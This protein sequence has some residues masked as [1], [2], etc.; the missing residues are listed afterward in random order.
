MLK[1]ELPSALLKCLENSLVGCGGTP[2]VI[3]LLCG[4]FTALTGGS[5]VTILA[6]GGLLLPMLLKEGY[7]KNFSLGLITVSGSVGLLFPPSLPLIIYGVTAGVSIKDIFIAGLFPGLILVLFISSWAVYQGSRGQLKLKNF[8]LRHALRV[9]WDTKWELFLPFL[10][11]F[12]VFGGYTTLVETSAIAVVY[13]FIVEVFIYKDIE[14][15][16]VPKI[17]LDCCNPNRGC[18]NYFRSCHGINKLSSRC[19][20]SNGHFKLDKGIRF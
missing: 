2:V 19:S 12:G 9:S 16:Y 6:L 1:V 4:F 15:S 13:I 20:G 5:G 7:S 11:I 3:I 10:I 14:I 18:V 17:V 8:I